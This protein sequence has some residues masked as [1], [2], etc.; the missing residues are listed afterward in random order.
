MRKLIYLSSPYSHKAWTIRQQRFIAAC[1][2]AAHLF[3]QG[4]FVF[5]PIAHCHPVKEVSDLL[6]DYGYW[7]DYNLCMIRKSDILMVLKLEGWADSIGVREEI[8]AARDFQLPC[9][10]MNPDNYTIKESL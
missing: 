6:G 7:K 4:Y 1:A 2:A 8:R 9:W 10:Q 5:S 3:K